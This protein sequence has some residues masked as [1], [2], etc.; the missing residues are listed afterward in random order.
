M[1]NA[2]VV[3]VFVCLYAAL[4][5][6]GSLVL[7]YASQCFCVVAE[8]TAA[9]LD[10]IKWPSDSVGEWM[11][12]ATLLGWQVLVWLAPVGMLLRG[13]KP[14]FVTEDPW[15][16]VMLFGVVL[17]LMFPIGV[18]SA[19]AGGSRWAFFKPKL[20]LGLGRI[21]PTTLGFYLLT[22]LVVVAGLAPWYVA[23]SGSGFPVLLAAPIGA[24]AVLIYAR[25]LGRLAW[26]LNHLEK[27]RPPRFRP[28]TLEK[29]TPQRPVMAEDPWGLPPAPKPKARKKKKREETAFAASEDVYG[30]A[31]EPEPAPPLPTELPV[32]GYAVAAPESS[33]P[34]AAPDLGPEPPSP[35]ELEMRLAERTP[36]AK[37]PAHPLFSGVWTFPWYPT[38]LRAWVWLA[39]GGLAVGGIFKLMP[40]LPG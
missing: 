19:M 40:T 24:A 38:T 12:R 4:G 30:L 16:V 11:G 23:L 20:L 37:P 39:M 5:I 9:G 3:I 34:P 18:L 17:W 13:L 32:D 8:D 31:T 10:E 15:L 22:G 29:K 33:S 6:V 14:A 35:S 21:L 26:R 28:P 1:G 2:G 27:V 25:L 36:Q 7:V